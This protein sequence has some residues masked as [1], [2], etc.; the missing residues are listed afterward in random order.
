MIIYIGF[1]SDQPE[2]YA[3]C[4]AS[5]E[6]YATY[7]TIK[8]LVLSK[9]K[10]EGIYKRAYQGESTEFA[11]TRFLVP[12]LSMFQGNALFCDSDFMWKCDPQEIVQYTNAKHSVYCV[13]HPSF[14]SP[15]V[16]MNDKQNMSYYRKYWSSLMYFDNRRCKKLNTEYVN[17]APAGDLH[18]MNWADSIGNLPAEFNAMVNYYYFD[19]PKAVHFT[20]GGPW[21]DIHDNLGYSN[22]WKKLYRNLQKEKILS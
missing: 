3:V 2:A 12:H 21:L 8:P 4:K 22:E 5:I 1:D 14:L 13:Q 17:Y 11:F 15:K 9:L 10:E 19:N 16:K 7:H 20:D 18:E 6:R